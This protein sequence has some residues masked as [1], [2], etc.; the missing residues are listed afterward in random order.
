MKTERIRIWGIVQGVG[1]RP[2]VAR[3]ARS[4][5]LSGQVQNAGGHVDIV[6]SGPAAEL[7]RFASRLMAEKPEPAVYIRVAREDMVAWPQEGF[8][9]AASCED[10]GLCFPA[11]DLALCA[12]CAAELRSDTD[13]RQ[14]H[15]FISCMHCGPRYSILERLPYD[16]EQTTMAGFPL[17]PDCAAEYRTE[18]DRRFH[19][20]TIACPACGPVLSYLDRAA[21]A[22]P[23]VGEPGL[24]SESQEDDG[25]LQRAIEAIR[26]G[27]VIAVKANSGFHLV[28]DA[29]RESAVAACREI[30]GREQK[31]FAVLFADLA[32][33]S[34]YAELS[35]PEARLLSGQ[36]RPVVL[37]R[38]RQP[39]QRPGPDQ[40]PGQMPGQPAKDLAPAT[41]RSSPFLGALL[42]STPIQALLAQACGPLVMT[43]ANRTGDQLI[44]E[45]ASMLAFARQ[46]PLLS[47]ILTHDRTILTGLDDSVGRWNGRLQ[48]LRRARGYVPLAID[49]TGRTT[50]GQTGNDRTVL[51]LGGDL[52]ATAAFATAGFAWLTQPAGDL[53]LPDIQKAWQDQHKHLGRLLG[54]KPDRVMIDLH[55]G[56]F[57][58]QAAHD[59]APDGKIQPVQHHHAH[60]ASVLAEHHLKGPVLGVAFDGTGFG[61]DGTVWG[62]EFLLCEGPSYRRVAHFKAI[63]LPGGDSG[64]REAWR[65]LAGYL[66]AAGLDSPD[67]L[68]DA[69][70][71][72]GTRQTVLRTSFDLVRAAIRSGI[73]TLANSSTGRLF[74]A[75]CAC[76]GLGLVN[77]YEGE[78]G[79]LL[80]WQAQRAR[81]MGWAA[82]PL[83][84]GLADRSVGQATDTPVWIDPAPVFRELVRVLRLR[85]DEETKARLALGFHQALAE[86]IARTAHAI[87][88][89]T[90]ITRLALS[91]GVF[92][93]GLLVTLLDEQL[94]PQGFDL[95]WNEQVPPHDGG[96]CLGQAW[97][98]LWTGKEN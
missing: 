77:H 30:K 67:W 94:P 18:E 7:D 54:Q 63:P 20:Q 64:M 65:S 40:M 91:G 11:P 90:G 10:D 81:D 52:K 95:Y 44:F 12:A 75:V 9:I 72:G 53:S 71:T 36:E 66:E 47:G 16:R 68:L 27:E 82:W 49:I 74:D 29:T 93:N 62:G 21:L 26:R 58:G 80:E 51:A 14:G 83:A 69:G 50:A 46:Q 73:N 70:W 33:L 97:L 28:C 31:P 6:V 2:F 22:S 19:A 78:C 17:C 88:T 24:A 41:A 60:I 55:P 89:A 1:M 96:I 84:F 35:E 85:Q 43:S 42:P 25:P 23:A 76:L 45:D 32:S 37:V 39:G 48:L 5:G 57:S 8:A 87:R 98:G 3:L 79:S 92:Q 34:A 4:L 59:L 38:P 56:Y 86:A 15:P 61:T 13:R